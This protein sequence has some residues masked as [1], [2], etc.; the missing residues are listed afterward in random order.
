MTRASIIPQTPD[1]YM[2]EDRPT[3]QQQ[4]AIDG[5]AA[6]Y[7]QTFNFAPFGLHYI[8]WLNVFVETTPVWFPV[9]SSAP[10]DLAAFGN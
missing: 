6:L 2:V 4:Q 9:S 3:P 1:L 5:Y 10:D 8:R 7:E